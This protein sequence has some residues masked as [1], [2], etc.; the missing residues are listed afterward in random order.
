M[1]SLVEMI[2]DCELSLS[3]LSFSLSLSLSLFLFLFLSL[4]HSLIALIPTSFILSVSLS[5]FCLSLSPLSHSLSL[6]SLSLP[7][8]FSSLSFLCLFHLTL[9]SLSLAPS[10]S[11]S[12]RLPEPGRRFQKTKVTALLVSPTCV[13]SEPAA[14][15][16]LPLTAA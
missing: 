5:L 12:P 3:L 8:P 10:A 6:L 16:C 9:V 4:S 13:S 1:G 11:L 7:L 2:N 15:L 14:G